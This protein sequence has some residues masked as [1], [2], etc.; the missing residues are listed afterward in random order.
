MHYTGSAF[1]GRMLE[2]GKDT[3]MPRLIKTWRWKLPEGTFPIPE[4][5]S[6]MCFPCG[7]HL[8]T[9]VPFVFEGNE[10]YACR[11]C[12]HVYEKNTD[13]DPVKRKSNP[14]VP[15]RPQSRQPYRWHSIRRPGV[16]EYDFIHCR[17]GISGHPLIDA[18][19]AGD[20]VD[21]AELI[22]RFF[23]YVLEHQRL[24]RVCF[25]T[26]KTE[27]FR[28]HRDADSLTIQRGEDT[29]NIREDAFSIYREDRDSLSLEF[30]HIWAENLYGLT[31]DVN[32]E[33][34]EDFAA[35]GR[36][37]LTFLG[38][39]R[40]DCADSIQGFQRTHNGDRDDNELVERRIVESPFELNGYYL[41]ELRCRVIS[42]ETLDQLDYDDDE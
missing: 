17:E 33:D 26:D 40:P 32:S 22:V 12:G 14:L 24:D 2:P 4:G 36:Y 31:L 3:E 20:P 13:P 9:L 19:G 39:D 34:W 30:S 41:Y 18:H 15:W 8:E 16:L 10:L 6:R 7:S 1:P 35:R 25:F 42:L 37:S 5:I 29:G 23:E 11:T 21:A 28:I 27:Q 38:D